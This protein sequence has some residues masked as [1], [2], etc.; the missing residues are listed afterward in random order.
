MTDANRLESVRQTPC[1]TVS[2]CDHEYVYT[3][4]EME[5]ILQQQKSTETKEYVTWL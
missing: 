4:G 2:G 5:G 1:E 3:F